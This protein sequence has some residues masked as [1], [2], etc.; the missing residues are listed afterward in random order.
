MMTN[1][2]ITALAFAMS[3]AAAAYSI[4]KDLWASFEIFFGLLAYAEYLK[5]ISKANKN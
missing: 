2:F 3:I 4:C 1:K 5:Q